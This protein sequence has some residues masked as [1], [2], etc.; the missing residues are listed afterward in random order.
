V[1]LVV[2]L[3]DE[4]MPVEK[5]LRCGLVMANGEAAKS[6][7][8]T[9]ETFD[10]RECMSLALE[11]GRLKTRWPRINVRRGRQAVEGALTDMAAGLAEEEV[12]AEEEGDVEEDDVDPA[13][14]EETL[15]AAPAE[16]DPWLR[17]RVELSRRLQAEQRCLLPTPRF[18]HTGVRRAAVA[19]LRQL[20]VPLLSAV[21][22]D[23]HAIAT[24]ARTLQ[25]RLGD[26][27]IGVWASDT[28]YLVFEGVRSV[29]MGADAV[30]AATGWA[31]AG[32]LAPTGMPLRATED[33]LEVGGAAAGAGAVPAAAPGINAAGA[34]WA[35]PGNVADAD[36][37]V[38]VLLARNASATAGLLGLEACP[39]LLPDCAFLAGCGTSE[40]WL[41][42][43]HALFN[44]GDA[45]LAKLH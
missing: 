3:D 29:W 14:L 22:D 13:A 35:G 1:R 24:A 31:T 45:E 16:A 30:F 43:L 27:F 26:R 36:D 34:A 9:N 40:K 39:H 44:D 12:V 25:D 4:R 17:A 2:V 37:V 38:M 33:T 32:P 7:R 42:M 19:A 21:G 18:I 10:A 8:V 28:D 23:D 5:A 15:A 6:A 20:R 11:G 41:P